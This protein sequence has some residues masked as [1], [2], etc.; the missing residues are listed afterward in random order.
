MDETVEEGSQD[1]TV[2]VSAED[3]EEFKRL[4]QFLAAKLDQF[5]RSTIKRL[6][7]D[8]QISSPDCK[9]E[10][11]KMPLAGTVIEIEVPPPLPTDICSSSKGA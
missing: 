5:S 1:L 11:K 2:T 4:D 6:F 10:L 8:E 7:E 9:L 3:R